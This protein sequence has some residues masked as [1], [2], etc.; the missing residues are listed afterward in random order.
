[1]L[2]FSSFSSAEQNDKITELKN[3]VTGVTNAKMNK[4]G[5][6]KKSIEKIRS[7]EAE[8]V[9]LKSENRRLKEMLQSASMGTNTPLPSPPISFSGS[10][11]PDSPV[12]S[13]SSDSDHKIVFLQRGI[14]PHSKFALCIFMFAVVALNNFGIFLND[15]PSADFGAAGGAP[16]R[17]TILSTILDEVRTVS[18][19]PP[20]NPFSVGFFLAAVRDSV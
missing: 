6:L 9:E 8:N 12:S 3:L 19:F 7:L 11:M 1:M 13:E 5:I 17:R 16:S 15:Q 14:S 4:S 2:V 20:R 18:P 10:P